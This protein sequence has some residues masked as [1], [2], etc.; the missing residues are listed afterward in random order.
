MTE[1]AGKSAGRLRWIVLLVVTGFALAGAGVY[2]VSS[3]QRLQDISA[4][5]PAVDVAPNSGTLPGRPY[6]LFRNTAA[7]Q[8]YGMATTVSAADPAGPRTIGGAPCDRVYGTGSKVVCLATKRGLVTSFEASIYG[9]DW[10]RLESWALPGIPSRTRASGQAG[11]VAATVFVTGHSYA[12][13]GFSTDTVIRS[14]DGAGESLNLEQFA[15]LVN[16]QQITASDRNLWGVTF[17]PGQ[18]DAFYATAA[19]SGRTWLVRGSI[20]A[21]TL[22]AVHDGVECPSIS[23][24]GTRIAF[25]K[26]T[27]STVTP[28][29]NIAVLELSS[30]VETVL[31]EDRNVDDQIEWSDDGAL[32]YGLPREGQAGDSDIWRISAAAGGRPELYI[33][34]AWSPSV[35]R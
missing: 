25:K 1:R 27:G 14:L 30:G 15:L 17:V 34:H 31:D 26:N 32:L 2:A 19:S 6:V 12:G 10:Q 7:G 23:P 9:S 16:G 29:W 35:V 5:V 13:T 22:T 8:G 21:R 20:S 28:H 18:E 24:D 3:F 4:A 33:E 11:L